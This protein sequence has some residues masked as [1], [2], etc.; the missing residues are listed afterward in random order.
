MVQVVYGGN[1]VFDEMCLGTQSGNAV[2]FF[3][4]QVDK[5]TALLSTAGA[6]FMEGARVLYDKIQNS[7]AARLAKAATRAMASIWQDQ[8]IRYL[9][10]M[11]ELQHAGFNMQRWIMA[12]PTL[13]TLYHK[14]GCDG[15]SDTYVDQEPGL[16]GEDHYDYRRVMNGIMVEDEVEGW[17]ATTWLDDL[18]E[19]DRELEIV[20][21]VDIMSTWEQ[22][23]IKLAK[24]RE[25]PTSKWAANL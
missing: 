11:G 19:D 16:V 22:V 8:E 9:C 15:Y 17:K 14:Q 18:L 5:S 25:D 13:R 10:T 4:D 7:D 20:E 24:K 6:R 2:Q 12:E 1:D 23:L 21:Q 3:Q